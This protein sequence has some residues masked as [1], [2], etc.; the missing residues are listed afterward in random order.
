MFNEY[1][2]KTDRK[3]SILKVLNDIF[4]IVPIYRK[5]FMS[6]YAENK[7]NPI[8]VAIKIWNYYWFQFES[9]IKCRLSENFE[10]KILSK[11]R[12]FLYIQVK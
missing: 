12:L 8:K 1:F 3:S 11:K 7:S 5:K 4:K 2:S 10:D 6:F 9:Y